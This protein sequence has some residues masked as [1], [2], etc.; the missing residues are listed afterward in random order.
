M[1]EPSASVTLQAR[2]AG[3]QLSLGARPVRAS[4]SSTWGCAPNGF[5]RSFGSVRT[6]KFVEVLPW[7]LPPGARRR[8]EDRPGFSNTTFCVLAFFRQ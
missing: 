4:Q 1:S 7:N 8:S 2:S 3:G 5:K 6:D